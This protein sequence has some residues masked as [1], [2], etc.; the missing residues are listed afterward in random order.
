MADL[1]FY[2]LVDCGWLLNTCVVCLETLD[3]EETGSTNSKYPEQ[4]D[5]VIC[6]Y[7]D[8]DKSGWI[9]SGFLEQRDYA[10]AECLHCGGRFTRLYES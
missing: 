8:S 9:P 1:V 2:P 6:A 3:Q 5:G 10:K 7:D 4:R